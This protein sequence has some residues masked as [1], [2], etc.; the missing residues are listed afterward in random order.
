MSPE[1]ENKHGSG[2]CTRGKGLCK[3]KGQLSDKNNDGSTV[4][5]PELAEKPRGVLLVQGLKCITKKWPQSVVR[6]NPQL[7]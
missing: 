5:E 6:L 4:L 3:A 1:Q 7:P 2:F